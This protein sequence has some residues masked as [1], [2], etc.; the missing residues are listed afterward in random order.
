MPMD[1]GVTEMSGITRR[2]FVKGA[3]LAP[4]ALATPFTSMAQQSATAERFDI[5]VDGAGH[6]SLVCAAYLG[7]AGFKVLVLEGRPTIGGGVKTAEV[8][9]TGFKEDLCSTVHSGISNNPLI[10][11]NELNLRDYGYGEYIDPDPV[12]HIPFLDGASI[13]VWR[14]LDRTCETIA[15][16][17]KKDAET[18]RRMVAE[19]KTYTA[20]TNA[21]RGGS[22]DGGAPKISQ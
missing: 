13:T 10:R 20:A 19:F 14:D 9:L 4:L 21:I 17:S 6:N 22:P 1:Q 2:G 18:F 8:C 15:R 11:N 16:V 5:V 7:K 3:A 12:M